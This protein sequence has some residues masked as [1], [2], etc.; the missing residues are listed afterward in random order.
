MAEKAW[1]TH[2]KTKIL[3]KK[4]SERLKKR[5]NKGTRGKE[6]LWK[7]EKEAKLTSQTTQIDDLRRRS[8]GGKTG[9]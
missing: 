9:I 5:G 2:K 3:E 8:L 7:T 4:T 1:Q 6:T